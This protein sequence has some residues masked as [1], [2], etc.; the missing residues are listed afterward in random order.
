MLWPKFYFWK[1]YWTLGSA[2]TPTNIEIFLIFLFNSWGNFSKKFVK[3]E[4]KSQIIYG[5]S[6]LYWNVAL[7][8]YIVTA[9][10]SSTTWHQQIQ[11][12]RN[13]CLSHTCFENC[14]ENLD[15]R[16]NAE[17]KMNE[18]VRNKTYKFILA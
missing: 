3:L 7:F 8:H 18:Q 14:N 16:T 9:I 11:N 4:T 6:N 2:S 15:K 12:D 1:A 5:E 17:I 13:S 10:K